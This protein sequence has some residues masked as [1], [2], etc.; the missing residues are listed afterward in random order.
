M[1]M[2]KLSLLDKELIINNFYW[3]HILFF[4]YN[5]CL[6]TDLVDFTLYLGHNQ[7][8]VKSSGY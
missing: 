7:S 3:C 5:I 1:K 4:T 8:F 2:V 6:P